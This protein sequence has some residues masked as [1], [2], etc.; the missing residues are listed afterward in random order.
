MAE[1]ELNDRA[2]DVLR[3]V[4]REFISTGDPVG[5]QQLT[6]RGDFEVSPATMRS[7]LGELEE[8]GYLEKPHTSAGRVPTG[9]GYR[10]FVDSLLQLRDPGPRE[11]ELISNGLSANGLSA[12]A[13]VEER[14]QEASKTLHQ[15]TQHA[16]VV[17]TPRASALTVKRIEFVR[18]RD[19]KV[20]AILVGPQGQVQNKLLS[21]DVPL[22]AEDLAAAANYLNALLGDGVAIED[23]RGR[24][25]QELDAERVQ[26]DALA[27]R[28]L[29][30]GA[31]ATDLT[32]PERVLLEGTHS[33]LETPGFGDDIQRM[34][35]LFKALDDKHKLLQL[36][37]RVQRARE[38]QIFIGAES[39]FSSQG[40]VSVIATPYGNADHVLGTLGVIGPTR[41]DYQRIIPLVSFTAQVLSRALE[42]P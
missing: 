2:R 29:K 25:L 12:N 37:D 35:T 7:V 21:V 4:V 1:N 5:S 40:D 26:Y 32:A 23:V 13:G 42:E 6:R 33:F 14:L 11:R 31:A 34:K 15:L 22:R 39:D 24:I 41:M 9:A 16:T 36:L 38:M 8:L 10:F 19:D 27:T 18:L 3:V 28:A 30:L 20:L 17:L